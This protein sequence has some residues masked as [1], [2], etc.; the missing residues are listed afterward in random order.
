M[1]E[2]GGVIKRMR[3]ANDNFHRMP[4]GMKLLALYGAAAP[5][6]AVLAM[7]EAYGTHGWAASGWFLFVSAGL[8]PAGAFSAG[9]LGMLYRATWSR[10]V[11]IS[12]WFLTTASSVLHPGVVDP[13]EWVVAISFT[14]IVLLSV[15]LYLYFGKG[16]KAYFS[17]PRA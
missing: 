16:P 12:G 7:A 1:Q 4:Y 11:F 2:S 6:M 15:G 9:A 17:P 3:V 8:A 5:S 10:V 14:S 13:A